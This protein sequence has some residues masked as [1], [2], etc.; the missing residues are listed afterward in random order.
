M[1]LTQVSTDGIKNG[2]I[3]GTDLATNVDLVDDQKLRLGTG[4]DLEIFHSSSSS[5]NQIQGASGVN[6]RI[7]QLGNGGALYLAAT[8]IYFQNHNIVGKLYYDSTR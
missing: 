4:N 1:A 8:N 6:T 2:T 7:R 3:T 5:F